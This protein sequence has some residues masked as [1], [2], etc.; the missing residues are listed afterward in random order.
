MDLKIIAKLGAMLVL[1]AS[2]TGCIDGTVDVEVTSETTARATLTQVM[3]ADFYA[4]FKMNTAEGDAA[5][6]EFCSEG[7]LVENPDGSATCTL[8]EEG[9]FEDLKALEGE[10]NALSF[11]SAGPGLVRVSLPTGEL[12]GDLGTG[13]DFDAETKQ[14]VEAFFAG[15]TL[16]IRI[17]GAEIT[18][19]NMDISADKKSAETELPFLDIINGTA[20]L[21]EELYAVVRAK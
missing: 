11:T 15:H 10:D 7:T 18:D 1:G 4:M 20:D 21:P 13:D 19:T 16:T 6:G 5:S 8:V 12:K 9:T 17:S 2:L 3:G 14:M